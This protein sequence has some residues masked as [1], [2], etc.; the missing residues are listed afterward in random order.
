MSLNSSYVA[1]LRQE[2]EN[3]IQNNPRYSM[4]A[5]SRD[6]GISSGRLSRILSGKGAPSRA[7]AIKMGQKMGYKGEKLEWY[8]ALVEAQH[9][10][11]PAAQEKARNVLGRFARGVRVR[12][13]EVA[14]SMDWKWYHFAIRRMT[15]LKNFRF[16]DE[17]ISLAL[18][19]D[20]TVVKQAIDQMLRAGVLSLVGGRLQMAESLHVH[21]KGQKPDRRKKLEEDL[22]LKKIPSILKAQGHH[23]RHFFAIHKSQMKEVKKIILDFEAKLEDLTFKADNP[24]ELMCLSV[25]LWSLLTNKSETGQNT[26]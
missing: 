21:F 17:W 4:R 11:T 14:E 6:L 16:D 15:E 22:F 7:T 18:D 8:C 26:K 12:H 2:L 3:R 9:G 5:F 13:V 10:R 20:V 23:P 25:D 1:V 24:D 19:I